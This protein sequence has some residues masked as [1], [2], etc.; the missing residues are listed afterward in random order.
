MPPLNTRDRNSVSGT[1]GC[2]ERASISANA[3]A[4]TAASAKAPRMTAEV[5]PL[6]WPSISA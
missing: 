2:A 6:S 4:A 1:I 5:Q 3:A